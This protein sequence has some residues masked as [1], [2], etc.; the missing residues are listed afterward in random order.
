MQ[1]IIGIIGPTASGKSSLGERLARECPGEIISCDSVQVYEGF[2]IGTNKP[3]DSIQNEIPHHLIDVVAPTD[4]FHAGRFVELAD[5]AIKEASGRGRIPLVVGGTGL[6]LRALL[7]GLSPAPVVPP[8]VQE[9]LEM[10]M[11]EGGLMPLYEELAVRDPDLA[12]QLPPTDTQRILRGLAVVR[13]TGQQ[14]SALNKAHQFSENRYEFRL[15]AI[16]HEREIL[17]ERINKRVQEMMEEGL[18]HEVE[19][20]LSRGIPRDC[21]PMEAPGYA[22]LV[23]FID[24]KLELDEAVAQIQQSHRRYAK[25]QM[26]WLNKTKE[27]EWV[28]VESLSIEGL[29]EWYFSESG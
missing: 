7:H 11:K 4:P 18:L 3:P 26:T 17:Y 21:R 24:G 9:T 13:G 8:G 27:V 16:P 14:L 29:R 2:Q 20:L 15:L 25:R 1:K 10:E 19:S 12:S 23:Q 6:Y 5:H 22:Q 28:D